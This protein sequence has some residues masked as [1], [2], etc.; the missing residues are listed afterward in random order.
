M[1]VKESIIA[2]GAKQQGNECYA[3]YHA[4]EQDSANHGL[5]SP[6]TVMAQRYQSEESTHSLEAIALS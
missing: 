3:Q 4:R 1:G 6:G 2:T 5:L